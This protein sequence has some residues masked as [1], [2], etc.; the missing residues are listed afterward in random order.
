M[1]NKIFSKKPSSLTFEDAAKNLNCSEFEVNNWIISDFVV[2]RLVPIVGFHPFPLNELM[3]MTATV[4]RFKPTLIFEWGT[5]IGKS[6]RVFFEI[7]D[8]FKIK[9]EI[10]SIDLPDTVFH[11]EHPQQNRGI[12]VKDIS[13]VFLHQADGIEKSLEIIAQKGTNDTVLFFVDGDHSYSSVK[14]ELATI[15]EHVP[16]ALVLLHDT[17]FQSENSGYNIGPYAA[18]KEVLESRKGEYKVMKTDTGLPGMTL[19]YK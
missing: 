5:N 9:T 17:F 2:N 4:C 7:T 11:N 19:V 15:L 8:A 13:S 10:H 6:A 16:N 18:I 12:M 1:I 3:L 14:K